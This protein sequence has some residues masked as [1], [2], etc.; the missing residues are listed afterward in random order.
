MKNRKRGLL[1]SLIIIACIIAAVSMLNY[2]NLIPKKKYTAEKFGIK[3]IKSSKD[4]NKNGIDDYTDIML[5]ARKDALN[6]PKYK[7]A[8][9]IGGY[10]PE[11]EGVCT[12]LVWRAFKNA[13]Y[14]LKDMVDED[15]KNNLARY[16]RVN[17]KPDKNIDFRRVPNLKVYFENNAVTC[18]LDPKDIDKWQPGDIVVFGENYTH[19]AIVS[20]KRNKKGVAYILH[21]AGQINREED[22]LISYSKKAPITGHYRFENKK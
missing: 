12:D 1:I 21:N 9:Y 6:K 5:G 2:Y 10:P 15:I 14:C 3:T 8:Y 18:S 13:G 22:A 11:N 7:S 19:I 17:G 20:D 4:Y 16:P